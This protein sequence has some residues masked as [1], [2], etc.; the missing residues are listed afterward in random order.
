MNR[1]A[2]LVA[3]ALGAGAAAWLSW[4]AY[5]SSP[6]S[7]GAPVPRRAA[8]VTLYA[9]DGAQLPVRLLNRPALLVFGYAT[10]PK[11]CPLTLRVVNAATQQLPAASRPRAIFVDVD[12]RDDPA[13]LQRFAERYSEVI[14]ATAPAD[15]LARLEISLGMRPIRDEDDVTNHDARVFVIGEGGV[16][17]G[18]AVATAPGELA[19]A[20]R[21]MLSP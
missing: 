9:T 2:R 21:G 8:D 1:I 6:S 5:H 14:A 7:F 17:V 13:T 4:F 15:A 19:S 16:L 12:P 10:C 11:T 18:T 3:L 20:L